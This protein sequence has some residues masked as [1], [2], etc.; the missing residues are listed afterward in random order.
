MVPSNEPSDGVL[1][2]STPG[3]FRA[4]LGE[5][6]RV[7][8]HQWVGFHK[9]DT[10]TPSMTWPESV[11]EALCFGWIDGLRKSVD[12]ARYAIRF[13][14]RKAATVWSRVNVRRVQAL[15]GEGRM[16]PAGLAAFEA[17]RE[18]TVGGYSYE[19]R[20]ADFPEPYRGILKANKLAGRYFEAQSASY[21]RTA[22]WWVISAK[23]EA[24]RRRRF[25]QLV[26][27]ST[28]SRRIPQFCRP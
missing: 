2:F 22:I 9:R 16:T 19:I 17:R 7:A 20:P 15:I 6:H 8:S 13:S 10:G 28:A 21:R 27:H 3:A 23:Q 12:K 14:P 18:N 1:Y 26:A 11:D 24:T 5:N 25:D 4:W